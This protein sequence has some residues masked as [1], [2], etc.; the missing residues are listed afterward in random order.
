MNR[1]KELR[2]EK[3]M[4]QSDVAK[5]VNKSERM[6]GFYENG[7]RD[8]NTKTLA[9]LAEIFNCSIDYLLGKSDI[10]NFEFAYHKETEGLSNEDIKEAL[11][12]YKQIKY[13]KNEE[14]K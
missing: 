8:P 7:E 11:R 2:L 4:L 3:N 6:I 14:K 5:L 12:I 10:R 9:K 13:G 1:I